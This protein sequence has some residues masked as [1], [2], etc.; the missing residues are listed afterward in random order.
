MATL[1][2]ARAT[3]RLFRASSGEKPGRRPANSL[4]PLTLRSL[5]HGDKLSRLA[6]PTEL[7]ES[8]SPCGIYE[9]AEGGNM[10][11]VLR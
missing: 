5:Y 9:L 7:I 1:E 4:T 11:P 6:L 2:A 8:H 3:D 10:A